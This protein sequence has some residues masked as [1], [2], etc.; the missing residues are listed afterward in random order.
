MVLELLGDYES[1]DLAFDDTDAFEL[2]FNDVD[3]TK[4]VDD[5]NTTVGNL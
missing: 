2:K 3:I 1:N 5:A 4:A